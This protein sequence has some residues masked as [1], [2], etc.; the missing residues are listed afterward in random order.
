MAASC[1]SGRR[2]VASLVDDAR[3]RGEKA[4]SGVLWPSTIGRFDFSAFHMVAAIC[5][6]FNHVADMM[7]SFSKHCLSYGNLSRPRPKVDVLIDSRLTR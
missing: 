3:Q 2:D 1:V 6:A 4:N 7:K 5:A